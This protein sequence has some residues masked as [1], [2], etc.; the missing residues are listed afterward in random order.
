MEN[1]PV[2]PFLM[3]TVETMSFGRRAGEWD[4]KLSDEARGASSERVLAVF[5]ECFPW[6]SPHDSPTNY[7]PRPPERGG[8]EG[9]P[10]FEVSLTL[11]LFWLGPDGELGESHLPD[12][13]ELIYDR[14]AGFVFFSIWPN[15]FTDVVP[16]YE[17]RS[18]DAFNSREMPWAPAAQRNRQRLAASLACWGKAMPGQILSPESELVDGVTNNGFRDTATPL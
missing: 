11:R 13:G 3:D 18:A 17:R 1:A 7:I 2:P 15:L 9:D 14:V 12:A 5:F 10:G 6:A 4:L 8:S 16:I